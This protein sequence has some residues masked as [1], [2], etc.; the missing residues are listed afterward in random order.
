MA[1]GSHY[2][3][4]AFE[5]GYERVAGLD[6]AGRG[7]LFGPVYAAAVILDPARPIRGLNDSKQVAAA[8]REQLSVMIR[9]RAIAWAVA[10]VEAA[11][12]DRINIY[13]ASRLAMRLAV[14]RLAPQPDYL[15]IDALR[16]DTRVPQLAIIHG[17]AR[18]RSIAAASILA[19]VER[20]ASMAAW[21]E[22]Y[23]VYGFL[24]H[25]G[26]ATPRHLEAL[27]RHGA[28]RHHRYSYSPVQAVAAADPQVALFTEA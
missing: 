4:E 16:I 22:M 18:C 6:E 21:H 14:E 2:E 12:I 19:K 11:E 3:R 7:C 24:E 5:S 25:K 28:T 23:P 15:L 20:D 10:S 26:Y 8:K 17:D 1:C 9:E 27:V 13:Q